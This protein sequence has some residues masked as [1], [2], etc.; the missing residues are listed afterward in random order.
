MLLSSTELFRAFSFGANQVISQKDYLNKINVF[1]VADGDTGSNLSATMNTLLS[2]MQEDNRVDKVWSSAAEGAWAGARGN[3]G[4]IFAQFLGFASEKTPSKSHIDMCELASAVK[5]AVEKVYQSISSPVEGTILTVMK[6]W[7]KSLERNNTIFE[8]LNS[9]L[10]QS[11]QDVQETLLET[12]NY[13]TVLRTKKVV[14]S[15]AKGFSLFVEGFTKMLGIE[16]DKTSEIYIPDSETTF[17]ETPDHDHLQESVFQYCFESLLG[18]KDTVNLSILQKKLE[19][20]GDSA[21]LVKR[22][23]NIKV[24]IHTSHPELVFDVLCAYGNPL[25][26]KAEDLFIQQSIIQNKKADVAIVT[27][28][29]ADIPEE[30]IR[31]LQINVIPVSIEV[32]GILH[33][34]RVTIKGSDFS[35]INQSLLEQ[36]KTSRPSSKNI[37][38]VLEFLQTQYKEILILCLSANLSGCFAAMDQ[39]AIK[40]SSEHCQIQVVDTKLNSG[41]QGLLVLKAALL[42][43]KGLNLKQIIPKI[44]QARKETKILV[45]LQTTKYL[46][47]SGRVNQKAEKILR[48]LSLKPMMTLDEDGN[49]IA[50][51]VCLTQKGVCRKILNQIEKENRSYGIS[52]FNV[53]HAD[54]LE[55]AKF[56]A[57]KIEEIIGIDVSY[58]SDI[59]PVVQAT[60]GEKAV[61]VSYMRKGG[62]CL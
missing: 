31:E 53:V 38:R 62:D 49:G 34:D 52:S 47:R 36:P 43:H 16:R 11:V 40:Y 21:L 58:I 32:A 45:A 51:G 57:G 50:Y 15:G 10:K 7:A 5:Y 25:E 6:A 28:S 17:L 37:E 18:C 20:L 44:E 41:A 27:D 54:N 24:H 8:D 12:P 2:Y 59:S 29:V 46:S 3:S 9:Y 48:R 19:P 39:L 55:G 14:D 42:A 30:L 4:L 35:K 1:P 13:L 33:L 56:L 61:A 22:R 23:N 26:I 60:A